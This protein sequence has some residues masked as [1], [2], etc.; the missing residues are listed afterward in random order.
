[1]KLLIQRCLKAK[2][3]IE[4]KE[5]ASINSGLLVFIGVCDSDTIN[6][7]EF[8]LNK[9]LKLRIFEDESGKTNLNIHEAGGELLLVSQFT[10]YANCKGGNRPSFIK[11]GDPAHAREIY[12]SF[13]EMAKQTGIKVQT[14]Q[15]GAMMEIELINHGP[16][17]IMLD[18]E[19]LQNG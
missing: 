1:M 11:A 13:V 15:F 19:E 6:T 3:S 5:T 17:T 8:M 9:L 7:A 18:S 12:E 14:G 2:V 10:L 16:F 4:G